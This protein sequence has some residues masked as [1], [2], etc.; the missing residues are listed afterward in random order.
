[1]AVTITLSNPWKPVKDWIIRRSVWWASDWAR[2]K[3]YV[4][5]VKIRAGQHLSSVT[6][7]HS[8]Y[9]NSTWGPNYHIQTYYESGP[10][11]DKFDGVSFSS[12]DEALA[13]FS[14]LREFIGKVTNGN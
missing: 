7:T 2:E 13:N 10:G 6:L 14:M 8:K 5:K 4:G 1:M 12:L 3:K 11:D 9:E